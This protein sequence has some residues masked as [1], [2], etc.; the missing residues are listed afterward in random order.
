MPTDKDKVYLTYF[1]APGEIQLQPD[2]GIMMEVPGWLFPTVK[3]LYRRIANIGNG[4]REVSGN[5]MKYLT[6][7]DLYEESQRDNQWG[8]GPEAIADATVV[9]MK[10]GVAELKPARYLPKGAQLPL[11]VD[12]AL[13]PKRPMPLI[14]DLVWD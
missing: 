3:W 1:P 10:L 4:K 5:L 14:N 6:L 13:V 9:L 11:R 8:V 2:A 7:D 12:F